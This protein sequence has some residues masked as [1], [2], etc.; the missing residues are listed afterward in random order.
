MRKNVSI[1]DLERGIRTK[2][3]RSRDTG[4]YRGMRERAIKKKE[5]IWLEHMAYLH[6][7]EDVYSKYRP[8]GYLSKG[9]VHCSC[10]MCRFKGYTVQD[11]KSAERM[12]VDLEE[13]SL[14][15]SVNEKEELR[16]M[17]QRSISA[18]D[19]R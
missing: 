15:F 9:K 7:K 12:I 2:H 5:K 1:D 6:D 16:K 4:Y 18:K 10:P 14:I 17:A 3:G 19:Y 11:S 8:S 13:T